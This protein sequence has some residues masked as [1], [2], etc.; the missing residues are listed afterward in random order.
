MSIL[1]INSRDSAMA[2]SAPALVS[3]SKRARRMKPAHSCRLSTAARIVCCVCGKRGCAICRSHSSLRRERKASLS[4]RRPLAVAGDKPNVC[5]GDQNSESRQHGMLHAAHKAAAGQC[6][7]LAEKKGGRRLKRPK[8]K[9]GTHAQG[10][11]HQFTGNVHAS[12]PSG[13][14]HNGGEA[15]NEAA[16][17]RQQGPG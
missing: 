2:F 14:R 16:A 9:E 1:T 4:H 17:T 11:G 12:D 13:R 3:A 5:R 15:M 6:S 7:F 10:D 8:S